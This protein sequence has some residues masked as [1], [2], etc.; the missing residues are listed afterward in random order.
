MKQRKNLAILRHSSF[1]PLPC[2]LIETLIFFLF[3][4]RRLGIC[5]LEMLFRGIF[6]VRLVI[7]GVIKTA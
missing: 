2:P 6:Q 7:W 1:L 5:G 4:A 3:L